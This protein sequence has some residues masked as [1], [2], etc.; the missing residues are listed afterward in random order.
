MRGEFL[1][2]RKYY[3]AMQKRQLHLLKETSVFICVSF[4]F[5]NESHTFL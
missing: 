3:F 5:K 2:H 4:F 1:P